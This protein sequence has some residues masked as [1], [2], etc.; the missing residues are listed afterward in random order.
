LPFEIFHEG[1]LPHFFMIR[2]E[3]YIDDYFLVDFFYSFKT[4]KTALKKIYW[5]FFFAQNH[6]QSFWRRVC[7]KRPAQVRNARSSVAGSPN[8]QTGNDKSILFSERGLCRLLC[9]MAN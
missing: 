5:I 7:I 2:Y 9:S 1:K 8:P 6:L 3:G 4:Q